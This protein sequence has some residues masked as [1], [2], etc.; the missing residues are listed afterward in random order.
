MFAH[1]F[2][3][4]WNK[5]RSNA[6]ITIEIALAFVVIFAIACFTIRN[7]NLYHLP[8]GYNYENMWSL[9]FLSKR[10]F[11]EEQDSEKYDKVFASAVDALR[12]MPEIES[13]SHLRYPTFK[14]WGVRTAETLEGK[15][16]E[17]YMN[18]MDDN[19]PNALGMELV[20]GRWFGIEDD[21]QHYI[22]VL[23]NQEFVDKYFAGESIVGKEFSNRVQKNTDNNKK[24]KSKRIVGVFQDFRQFGE[25]YPRTP[26]MFKRSNKKSGLKS[27]ELKLTEKISANFEQRVL[28]TFSGITAD[29]DIKLQS[30]E[31]RRSAHLRETAVPLTIF[32]IVGSFL[33]F[34]V[35]MGLFGVIWQNV[36][37]RKR[38]IGLR[39]ALGASS[40]SIHWQIVAELSIVSLFGIAIAFVFL[41][42]LP[43]LGV[44]EELTWSLFASSSAV[45][46]VFMLLLAAIC[47]YYPG[48]L[49]TLTPPAQALHYE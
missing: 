30:W 23:V 38:E 44:H 16:T 17:F 8:L 13:I 19:V 21:G 47:A 46:I 27:S 35:A 41:L 12:Q 10:P 22:P 37:T 14:Q 1:L 2:K 32:A 40:G 29:Y 42:Q 7:Y 20:E 26:Y 45:S 9:Q 39:R 3:M 43:L 33:L 4:I 34:M 15:Q 11:D 28:D 36:S 48:K 49:A 6:L 5:K 31:Q 25:L 18:V 24:S